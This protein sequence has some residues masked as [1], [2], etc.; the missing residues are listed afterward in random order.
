MLEEAR[1]A[2]AKLLRN[3]AN[4]VDEIRVICLTKSPKRCKEGH[5]A[6][7]LSLENDVYTCVTGIIPNADFLGNTKFRLEDV[8][9][10]SGDAVQ[11][12]TRNHGIMRLEPKPA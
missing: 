10:V 2:L 11:I 4:N 8:Q 3:P 9:D 7:A 5:C 6:A 1:M 12:Q